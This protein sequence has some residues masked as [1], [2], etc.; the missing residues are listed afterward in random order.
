MKLF[1][2][3]SA[4]VAAFS[5][6]SLVEADGKVLRGSVDNSAVY[7]TSDSVVNMVDPTNGDPVDEAPAYEA[8]EECTADAMPCW[9]SSEPF[10]F[11]CHECC[12]GWGELAQGLEGGVSFGSYCGCIP[13][14]L[15]C[16]Q[17]HVGTFADTHGNC[18]NCCSEV[19]PT[20]YCI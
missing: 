1:L 16:G 13:D 20:Y 5:G 14:Q 19:S 15:I 4:T 10:N 8:D 18:D 9:Q 12:N 11:G 7:L 3:F 6:T 2:V 17:D